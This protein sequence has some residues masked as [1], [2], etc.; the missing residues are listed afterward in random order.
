[1]NLYKKNTLSKPK[2]K[3]L[4][5]FY[6]IVIY[7][8]MQFTWWNY[9]MVELNKDVYQQNMELINLKQDSPEKKISEEKMLEKKLHSRWVMVIGESSV[10]FA[11]ILWG[12]YKI[13]RTFK[14]ETQL[15]HRE[16][17]FLLSVTHE[18]K[19]PIASIKLQLQTLQRRQ[20]NND[21][22]QEIIANAITD[23]ERINNLVENI[24]L[25][26]RIDNKAFSLNREKDNLSDFVNDI[27]KRSGATIKQAL[28]TEIEENIYF[29]FDKMSFPS[30]VINML[31]N[32]A[33]YAPETS[34][35]VIKLYKK[36]TGVFLT[37]S[38]NGIGIPDEHKLIIFEKFYRVENE[39]TRRSKGTGLG[40]FIV[41]YLVE[42]HGGTVSVKNNEPRGSIFKVQFKTEAA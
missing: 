16:K 38:D 1:L 6:I 40:L 27:V 33:K 23:T 36:D 17:N 42:K 31:E 24:L 15:A 19:S 5:W 22:Q 35:I 12:T 28:Q 14:K 9:L 26:A 8:F 7:V 10:F 2:S 30:I 39:E 32:A 21:K 3:P 41:H 25:T 18:L 4:V 11:L 29:R 13:Q 20:L 37:V 34:T